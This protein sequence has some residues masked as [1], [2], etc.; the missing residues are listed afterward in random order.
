MRLQI[1]V[2]WKR[3]LFSLG[4]LSKF[5]NS[6]NCKSLLGSLLVNLMRD[7]NN[8]SV[9]QEFGLLVYSHH[10]CENSWWKDLLV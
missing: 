7:K 3:Q 2:S 5:S 4:K 1:K 6:R 8:I 10:P 9:T